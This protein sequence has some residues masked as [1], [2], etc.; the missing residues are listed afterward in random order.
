[1]KKILLIL[2][3][4]GINGI[5]CSEHINQKSVE[6]KLTKEQQEE[7]NEMLFK[8]SYGGNLEKVEEALKA[9]ADVNKK[10]DGLTALM[11]ASYCGHTDI[12]EL[13]ITADA[14]INAKDNQKR[15]AL[16]H[17][18][19]DGNKDIVE[20]LIKAGA[21]INA[22]DNNGYTALICASMLGDTDIVELLIKSGA[23]LNAKDNYGNTALMLASYYANKDIIEL[24]VL[25][26]PFSKEYHDDKANGFNEYKKQVVE[27]E[28]AIEKYLIDDLRDLTGYLI[29]SKNNPT[30]Q[31]FMEILGEGIL[32]KL[33]ALGNKSMPISS[34]SSSSSSSSSMPSSSSSSK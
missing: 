24:L 28:S 22:K 17:A 8:A 9:G 33:N 32:E 16:M 23:D 19:C 10:Y 26:A 29:S 21:D 5:N 1:M 15:T 25:W 4:V 6:Q 12:I 31:D 7:V 27:I 18:S 13:L 2:S 3:L 34:L 11:L 20:I 14:D 30:F